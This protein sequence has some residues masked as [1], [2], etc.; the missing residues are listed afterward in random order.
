M[1]YLYRANGVPDNRRYALFAVGLHSASAA[2]RSDVRA[3]LKW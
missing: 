1:R 2:L 3:R